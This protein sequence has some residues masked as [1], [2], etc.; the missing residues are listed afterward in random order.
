MSSSPGTKSPVTSAP[1]A[2]TSPFGSA[3]I[4]SASPLGSAPVVA[5]SWGS[6][7]IASAAAPARA[8]Q[9]QPQPLPQPPQ[10]FAR[11]GVQPWQPQLP[12]PHP[13]Q[14]PMPMPMPAKPM[15]AAQPHHAQQHHAPP[16]MPP[17]SAPLPTTDREFDQEAKTI[18]APPSMLAQPE[19]KWAAFERLG[20]KAQ[21]VKQVPAKLWALFERL[22]LDKKLDRQKLSTHIVTAYRLLGFT[23]LSIIVVVLIAYLVTTTFFF[24]SDSWIVPMAI[25]PTDEKVVSLQS[26]LAERQTN[27]DRTAAELDQ[28]ERAIAVQQ[29]FQLEFAK[30]I[31]SDLEG[32]KAALKRMY[33]LSSIASSTRAKIKRSNSAYAT[34]QQRRMA[35]EWKAG[36]IDRNSML[37][38]KFQ[39]A[40]ISGS[41]LQLAERQAE[42]ETR[43][44]DLDSQTRSLESLLTNE[45]I[46]GSLSYDVLKI[47]QEYE[48][49]RLETAR[50]IQ[51]RDMLKAAL[52]REDKLLDALKKSSY[53]KAIADEAHVAFV[54]YGNMHNVKKGEPVYGCWLTM[55]FCGKVGTVIEVLPGEVQFKHPNRDKM[56]RGQLVEMKLDEATDATDDVLFV[57][58]R[59]LLL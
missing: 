8:P 24:L 59:P 47:K 41:N 27:R 28:A 53:L 15:S 36:L 33:E 54:P 57:G 26:Q 2:S 14:L 40:Q 21:P 31:K 10:P 12:I 32:R 46:Q 39:I 16:P 45:G 25:S 1:I 13:S 4:A 48:A 49:S 5:S 22:G 30:A 17:A 56:M 9:P 7:A 44:A 37:N 43:A 6:A 58:G 52:V 42:Y 35:E 29:E 23:I 18:V 51:N 3:P 38:G 20:L 55:V 19:S 11:Q 34:A 50:A